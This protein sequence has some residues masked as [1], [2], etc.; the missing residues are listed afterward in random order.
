MQERV[1][2]GVYL[3]RNFEQVFVLLTLVSVVLINYWLPQKI[4]IINFYFLP[5]IVAGYLVGVRLSVLGALFCV[6][7]VAFYAALYPQHFTVPRSGAELALHLSAWGGFLILA[8]AVVGKQQERLQQ[9][10]AQA[11]QLNAELSR[12]YSDLN[13][14]RTATVL[15]LAK[16]AEYRDRETGQHL[17]R[18]REY[19]RVLAGQLAR[20]PKYRD[21]ITP[22]Y[23]QDIYLSSILHDIGKVGI[24]DRVL[25]KPGRLTAAEFEEVKRH[26]TLGGEA[27]RA[28]EVQLEGESFLTLGKEV[29]FNHHE[30]WDGRGYPRGLRGQEIPLSAR[31][32]AV[33]DVYD[34]V[35]SRRVYKRSYTHAEAR[36]LIA[37][38]RGRQ[39]DPDVVDAFLACADEF[40][41]IRDRLEDQAAV[42]T[43]ALTG[44]ERAPGVAEAS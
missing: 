37:V 2:L 31:I 4:A 19:S 15:G 30:H 8:G 6:L 26:T 22:A 34:A 16:L 43:Q 33:A 36:G 38:D 9:R 44:A 27:L 24:A 3:R 10:I 40:A 25:C 39:F 7:L 14:A 23:V 20:H 35:T 12:S 11:L 32:V 1:G 29:A 5:V 42:T 18:I 13:D 21:Y 41:A 28:V 17:E